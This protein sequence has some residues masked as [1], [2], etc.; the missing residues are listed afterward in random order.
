MIQ[1]KK[2]YNLMES[3]MTGVIFDCCCVVVVIA[4]FVWV[5]CNGMLAC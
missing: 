4:V 3:K 1:A 2:D 5:D